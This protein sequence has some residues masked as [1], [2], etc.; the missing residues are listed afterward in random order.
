MVSKATILGAKT[1]WQILALVVIAGIPITFNACSKQETPPISTN[2]TNIETE[3]PA[4]FQSLHSEINAIL[5]TAES[6]IGALP[7]PGG[8]GPLRMAQVLPAN[9]SAG[10]SLLVPQ[11]LDGTKLFISGLKNIG[12][13]GIVL[14]IC[15]PMLTPGF[16]SDDAGYLSF[17]LQ[18]VNH[19]RSL[20]LK[21]V[22]E[23]NSILPTYAGD[24][25][26]QVSTYF[27]GLTKNRFGS[28]RYLELKRIAETLSPD[29]LVLVSEPGTHTAGLP[30]TYSDWTV[31]VS[32]AAATLRSQVPT[33][34][35]KLGAGAGT[36][37]DQAYV[38]GFAGMASLDFIDM[39]VYP[40][41]TPA[42]SQL[43]VFGNRVDLVKGIS[44]SKEVISSEFWLYKASPSE[45]VNSVTDATVFARDAYSFWEKTD[46][47][48][49]KALNQLSRKK[50]VTL[51]AGFWSRFFFS[52]L[53]YGSQELIGLDA[54]G[55]MN[56]ANQKAFEAL[57]QNQKTE[58]GR[59]YGAGFP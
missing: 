12:A 2:G 8:P 6:S 35:S 17:Y 41:T 45:S 15:Y 10:P 20:G 11:W 55:I 58:L 53:E 57:S 37:E 51:I 33:L 38:S 24:F 5:E 23:H 21:I 30:L 59:Q 22:V 39:H 36:W 25:G 31:Y 16:T 40:L 44:S 43:E 29:Y 46:I 14:N 19:A 49:M 7:D 18:I 52:Y 42:G 56:F 26:N 47:R 27:S 54:M 48:F 28:E 1:A 34:T 9:C 50:G 32:T 3:I 13:E 4:K